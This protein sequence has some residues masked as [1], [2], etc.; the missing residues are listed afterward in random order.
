MHE[1]GGKE[2]GPKGLGRECFPGKDP[3]HSV[4]QS[5]H[6]LGQ[7]SHE[8]GP[9]LTSR[10]GSSFHLWKKVHH[11]GEVASLWLRIIMTETRAYKVLVPGKAIVLSII[12]TVLSMLVMASYGT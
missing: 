6:S 1:S 3:F 7:G 9:H 8:T 4:G 12:I 5:S 11:F 2:Q 10:V